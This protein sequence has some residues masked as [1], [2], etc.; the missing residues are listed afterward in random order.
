MEPIAFIRDGVFADVE[1]VRD[2]A[3]DLLDRAEEML[4]R[5]KLSEA[6]RMFHQAEAIGAAPDRCSSGRWMASMLGGDFEG[7]WRESDAI[8]LRGKPDPHRFWNGEDLQG[9]RVMVRCLHGFGDAVQM[10]RYASQ[11]R[12]IASHVIFEVPQQML[13]LAP[14]FRNVDETITWGDAA[15]QKP[16]EWDVQVEI[17]EL[18][19]LF[20]TTL[21][22]LPITTSYLKLPETMVRQTA[23]AMG[24]VPRPRIGLVWASGEWNPERSVPLALL[25]PLIDETSFEFWTLQGDTA[26]NDARRWI[27]AGMIR[28]ARAV[29]RDGL[30]SLA[31][32]I[33][34]L[35]LV[36][37]VDTLAAHLAGALGKPAWVMLQYS[38]DWRW[39]T[40]RED[41]PWYPTIR[42]FRQPKPGDW[43]VTVDTVRDALQNFPLIT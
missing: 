40:A 27:K 37:T 22:E 7:A 9:A 16:P 4:D 25:E 2:E 19:Y 38:A 17:T 28:D 1:T 11:L 6:S 36:I 5:R 14:L 15:P 42:L 32:T 8:R 31:A 24:P 26:A 3:A 10:L 41:S 18:P 30:V 34:N 29:C 39:M 43:S 12:E 13:S 21:A 23:H 33:A 35:D 20:R